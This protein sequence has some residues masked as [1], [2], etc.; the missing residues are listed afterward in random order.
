MRGALL[1]ATKDLLGSLRDRSAILSAVIAPLALAFILSAA[2]G[3]ADE[4]SLDISFTVVDEDRGPV[5]EV[6][7]GDVLGSL[8]RQDVVNIREESSAASARRMARDG[9]IAAAFLIPSGFSDAVQ[10]GDHVELSVLTDPS[11]DIGAQ[12][13]T[14]IANGYATELNAV[15]AS[16]GTALAVKGARPDPGAI[17]RLG[18]QAARAETPVA[19]A[20]AFVGSREFDTKTFFVAGMAVFFLFFTAQLGAVS[21]LRERREGTLARLLAAPLSRASILGGKALYTFVLGVG[22]LTVLVV[23]SQFLLEANWGDPI[24]VAALIIAGV[25]AA[26]GLQ[27]LVATLAKNNEQAAGYGAVVGVTLGLLGGTFFPLSQ[28]P[29][30]IL[31]LSFLTPHAWLMRGFGELSGGVAGV[32]DVVPSLL[33]LLAMGGVTGAIALMRS[34]SLVAVVAR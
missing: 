29:G 22:S 24:G 25:F 9:D 16:V 10:S 3:N 12:I 19:V 2:L 27:S 5:A 14:S 30:F 23:S 32:A 8:E 6:F 33:A 4:G 18:R 11:S 20:E 34:R 31:R 1:I 17:R 28:A 7:V 21:L 13:A 15:R 26:M